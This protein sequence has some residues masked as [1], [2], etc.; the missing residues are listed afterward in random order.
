MEFQ[1]HQNFKVHFWMALGTLLGAAS[2]AAEPPKA[3][4]P[5]SPYIA[6]VYRYADARLERGRD[7]YGPQETGLFLSALDRNTAAVLKSRPSAP[8]GV[9]EQSR[10]GEKDG[11]LTGANPQH[12]QNFL[13]LLYTL[14][15]LS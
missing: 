13:R 11:P 5:K 8:E 15:E 12:D 7:I 4:V 6:V 1:Q 3:P 2:P 10:V 14:S 9:S